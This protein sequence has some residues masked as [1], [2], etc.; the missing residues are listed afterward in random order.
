MPNQITHIVLTS[1]VF[2]ETFNKFNKSE[3]YIGTV[4][5]DIRFLGAIDR[6]KT[7]FDDVTLASVLKAKTSF[8]AGL[9]FHNLTDRIFIENVINILPKISEL[10]DIGGAVKLLADELFYDRVNN[11]PEIIG[12]F[13]KVIPE[14]L[15]FSI[16]ELDFGIAEKD[17]SKWHQTVS[18]IFRKRPTDASNSRFMRVINF[19]ENYINQANRSL[20]IIRSHDDAVKILSDFYD[21]FDHLIKN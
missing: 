1:K 16:V 3:F 13:D 2:T 11:W 18:G 10:P 4:F 19:S 14:E 8:M 20:P 7:H 21:N 15:D 9:L 12:Y 6:A 5:P 17:L